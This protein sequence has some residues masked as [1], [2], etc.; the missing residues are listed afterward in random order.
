MIEWRWGES[1]WLP[2]RDMAAA[3]AWPLEI[4]GA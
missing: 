4:S 2:L 1:E 3:F